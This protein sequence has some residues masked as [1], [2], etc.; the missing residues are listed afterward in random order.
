M[1][2]PHCNHSSSGLLQRQRTPTANKHLSYLAP[3]PTQCPVGR[4]TS[5]LSSQQGPAGGTRPQA[6]QGSSMEGVQ[7]GSSLPWEGSG[8]PT[9]HLQAGSLLV[10]SGGHYRPV[11]AS[12]RPQRTHMSVQYLTRPHLRSTRCFSLNPRTHIIPYQGLI[13]SL[14]FL[15]LYCNMLCY[16]LMHFA[17]VIPKQ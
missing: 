9:H 1:S 2:T 5:Y 11:L 3:T 4:D 12:T 14:Y 7:A 8:H 17:T 6:D 16:I 15:K 13:L 10:V